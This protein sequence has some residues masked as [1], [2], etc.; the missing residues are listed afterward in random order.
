M[1]VFKSN[2]IALVILYS[3]KYQQGPLMKKN[4]SSVEDKLKVA[5]EVMEG[6]GS[7]N[8]DI[9]PKLSQLEVLQKVHDEKNS[10]IEELKKQIEST[11]QRLEKKEMTGDK[12]G[13]FNAL[14]NKYNSLREEY[15]KMLTEKSR[16]SI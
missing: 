11:K 1:N 15:N 5:S 7:N 16:E 2:S 9:G 4:S 14:S 6:G 13:S 12:M 8:R 10:R 3:C